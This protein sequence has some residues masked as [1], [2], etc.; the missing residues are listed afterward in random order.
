M[1]YIIGIDGGGTKTV[2]LLGDSD[3]TIHARVESGPSNYHVVGEVQTQK[4]LADLISR[5]LAQ[6]NATLADC[7]GACLGMAGLARPAD[8]RIIDR[9]CDEICLTPNRMLT[10]DAQIALA[11]GAGKCEGVV[12]I[13]GTGSIV[14][15]LNSQ[16]RE[17]RAGGW[18]HL[19]GDEG[20][21]YDIA[22]RGLRAVARAAD[23][24]G[25]PTQVTNLILNELGLKQP[26]DLIPWIH[27]A[28]K[29]QVAQLAGQVFA[30]VDTGGRVARQII[31]DAADELTIAAKVVID[32]LHFD[33]PFD[34]V[35]SGGIFEHQPGFVAVLRE[36]LEAVAPAAQIGLPKH[37]PAYGALLLAKSQ[38]DA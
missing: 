16:G 15:G 20:S 27:A 6:A 30:A 21:G 7:T 31:E 4:V 2:G 8:Q 25:T 5:L 33:R 17:E 38:F 37:E 34:V 1:N 18:G 22:W 11:G 32:R 23:G 26:S 36:R 13:A 35:L 3:G 28:S 10:N 24:R 12:I 9:L 29:D 14:Y 19:L